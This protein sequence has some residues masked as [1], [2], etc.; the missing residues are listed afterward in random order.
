[1]HSLKS[2]AGVFLFAL[3]GFACATASQQPAA[4]SEQDVE[5]IRTLIEQDFTAKLAAHDME[6]VGAMLTEAAVIMPFGEPQQQGRAT[7]VDILDRNW[8]VLPIAEFTQQALKIDGRGDLAYAHGTYSIK[9]QGEGMPQ[10]QDQ[11]KFL[12]IF[13]KQADGSWLM[14]TTSYSRNIPK[15]EVSEE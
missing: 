14:S 12:T 9:V 13:E 5:A 1:M 10:I 15:P 7:I 8:G 3:T 6:S 4:L 11:G 2:R